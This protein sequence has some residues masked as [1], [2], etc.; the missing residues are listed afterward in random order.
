MPES[1]ELERKLVSV[2]L[3]GFQSYW[4]PET[5]EFDSGLTLLAGKNDVGKSALLRALSVFAGAPIEGGRQDFQITL[6]SSQRFRWCANRGRPPRL[7][8]NA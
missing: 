6:R 8:D 1:E 3:S 7:P 5:V 4:R 2:T